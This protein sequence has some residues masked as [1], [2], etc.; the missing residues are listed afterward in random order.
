MIIDNSA[1]GNVG[2]GTTGPGAQLHI[3]SAEATPGGTAGT[4]D[5]LYIQP[6]SNTGGPY[7]FK[8]RTVSGASDYLDLYYGSNHIISWGL[9]GNV[10]IGNTAPSQ[11]LTVEGNISGSGTGSFGV[12]KTG[13]LE[14]ENERGHWK[15]I[16]ESE[17]LSIYNVKTDKKFKF[18]LEEIE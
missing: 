4:V 7:K 18:V 5:R 3:G 2:I 16:E 14:L 9:N 10:G 8:A 15:I 13:D 6:Y 12:L 17:Y 1:G 11:P